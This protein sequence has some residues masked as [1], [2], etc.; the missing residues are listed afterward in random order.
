MRNTIIAIAD[1]A[2]VAI[3]PLITHDC[4]PPLAVYLS[5]KLSPTGTR[6]ITYVPTLH[7]IYAVLAVFY[8]KHPDGGASCGRRG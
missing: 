4:P 3:H 6:T 7:Q 1:R 8:G 2:A 5:K